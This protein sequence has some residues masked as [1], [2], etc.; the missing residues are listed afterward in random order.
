MH[1]NVLYLTVKF[2]CI[3]KL[4]QSQEALVLF[5]CLASALEMKPCVIHY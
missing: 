5:V 1:S 2:V 3:F 4:M